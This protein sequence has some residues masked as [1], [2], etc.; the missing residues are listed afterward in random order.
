MVLVFFFSG[1]WQLWFVFWR[2]F[3]KK[4]LFQKNKFTNSKAT[5]QS[6]KQQVGAAA[7]T[8]LFRLMPQHFI[9]NSSYSFFPFFLFLFNV[10]RS[11]YARFKSFSFIYYA[12]TLCCFLRSDKTSYRNGN[13]I[14]LATAWNFLVKTFYFKILRNNSSVKTHLKLFC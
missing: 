2:F 4:A 13:F 10:S 9:I 6:K 5:F 11:S 7:V 1:N 3:V 8:V 14:Y 12:S